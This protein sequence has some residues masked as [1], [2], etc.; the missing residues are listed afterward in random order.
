VRVPKGKRR[1]AA[2]KGRARTETDQDDLSAPD[3][4]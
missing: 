3:F 4:Q 1:V 2:G